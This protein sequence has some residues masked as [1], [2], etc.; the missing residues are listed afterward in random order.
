MLGAG[1][2]LGGS[3]LWYGGVLLN[4]MSLGRAWSRMELRELAK[5]E[6]RRVLHTLSSDSVRYSDL[7]G[8]RFP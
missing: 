6:P 1:W 2:V 7:R 3:V 5:E 4:R 8:D